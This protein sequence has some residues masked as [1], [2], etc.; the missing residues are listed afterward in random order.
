VNAERDVLVFVLD[1][2][3]TV[4]VDEEEHELQA[5]SAL[6]VDKGRRRSITAGVRGVRYLSAHLRRPPLQIRSSR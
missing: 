6:I 4:T 1:G 3:A 2:S 5:G